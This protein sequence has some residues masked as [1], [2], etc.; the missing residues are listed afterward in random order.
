MVQCFGDKVNTHKHACICTIYYSHSD[1]PR[2]RGA[3]RWNL[4]H[5]AHSHDVYLCQIQDS[6]SKF[7]FELLFLAFL[8]SPTGRGVTR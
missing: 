5:V 3:A 1:I 8:A 4:A 2:G 6:R 7:F